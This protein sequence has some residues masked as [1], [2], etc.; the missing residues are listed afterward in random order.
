MP[1]LVKEKKVEAK[2]YKE[3]FNKFIDIGIPKDLKRSERFLNVYVDKK[4]VFLDRDGVINKD[5]GYVHKKKNFVEEKYFQI[6]KFF[7]NRGYLV[8]VIT[9]QSGVGRGYYS[10]KDVNN[11]HNWMNSVFIDNGSHIDEFYYSPYYKFSTNK[12]FRKNEN[13][14]KPGIGF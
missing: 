1:K 4:A 6:Y 7:K 12:K 8:F 9:N 2:F 3:K 13:F 10:L 11:L 5:F 14:R